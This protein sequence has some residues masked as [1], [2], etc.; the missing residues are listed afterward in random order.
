[1]GNTLTRNFLEF[2]FRDEE[3]FYLCIK[4][5][6][7]KLEV[8]MKEDLQKSPSK[9]RNRMKKA[10]PSCVAVDR[11]PRGFFAAEWREKR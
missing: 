8:K 3:S 4:A 2:Y 9:T 1:M 5:K 7:N 11:W 6:S 10:V